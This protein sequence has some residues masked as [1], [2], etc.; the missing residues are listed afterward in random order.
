L[1]LGRIGQKFFSKSDL[2][3][4]EKGSILYGAVFFDLQSFVYNANVKNPHPKDVALKF[5][6]HRGARPGPQGGRPG[7]VPL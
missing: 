7:A 2:V 6:P 4:F 5:A 3:I 1:Q